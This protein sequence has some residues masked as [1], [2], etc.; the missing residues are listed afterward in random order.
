MNIPFVYTGYKI[1]FKE[2]IYTVKSERLFMFDSNSSFMTINLLALEFK[3]ELAQ[4]RWEGTSK[5]LGIGKITEL[6]TFSN[7]FRTFEH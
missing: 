1:F 6:V 7:I 3:G 4:H 2:F 5:T